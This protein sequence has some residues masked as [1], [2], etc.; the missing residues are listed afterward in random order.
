[1]G[2]TEQFESAS[3]AR[4]RGWTYDPDAKFTM[5]GEIFDHA[6]SILPPEIWNYLQA[7]AGQ[8]STLGKN[9]EAFGRWELRQRVMSGIS[10]PDLTTTFLGI[11]LSMPMLTAPFAP[12]R[13]FHPDGHVAIAKANQRFGTASVVPGSASSFSLE[14]I[15]EAAPSAARI[16]QINASLHTEDFFVEMIKRAEAA[17]YTAICVTVDCPTRGWR[18]RVMRDRFLPEL[19][20]REDMIG[21]Y[22]DSGSG[23]LD[24]LRH[25]TQPI[26]TWEKLSELCSKVSLPFSAKGI[27]TAE[28]ARA[29][30][31]AGARAVHVS[32]H[33]GRQLDGV[34]AALDQLPEVVAEVGGEVEVA[35]DSGIRS[36]GDILKALALGARV[37]MIGRV[38]AMGLAADG[39]DGVY[40]VLELLRGELAVSLA[41][42]GRGSVAEVDSTLLQER[43]LC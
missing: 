13:L 36:G 30:V 24:Y 14:D 32:N 10:P 9:R 23:A 21:N 29:A 33:G 2:S 39:E 35:F 17:G 43:R 16:F 1:M 41:L 19:D 26:W 11:P 4:G 15:A 34:P 28:D 18:E 8:E 31:E 7:G 6:E 3:P 37:V 12:G 20:R 25:Y 40:R 27:L 5:L 22:G 38:A 42:V